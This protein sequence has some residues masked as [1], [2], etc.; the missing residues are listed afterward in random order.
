ME[1]EGRE[2]EFASVLLPRLLTL[3][4]KMKG[5]KIK[6]IHRETGFFEPV[7]LP[8]GGVLPL[9][10]QPQPPSLVGAFPIEFL[11]AVNTFP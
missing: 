4:M 6:P 1:G 5:F 3:D 7:N 8:C 10:L 9:P 11:K 2:P